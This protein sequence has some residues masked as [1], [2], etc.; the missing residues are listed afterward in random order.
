MTFALAATAMLSYLL[1]VVRQVD[2]FTIAGVS[3]F[4][5]SVSLVSGIVSGPRGWEDKE[6]EDVVYASFV[7]LFLLI[8]FSSFVFDKLTCGKNGICLS[9]SDEQGRLIS[10]FLVSVS[11]LLLGSLFFRYGSSLIFGQSKRA[12]MD[13]VG[14]HYVATNWVCLLA[15]TWCFYAS[16]K[17]GK[18]YAVA[19]L[20]IWLLIGHRAPLVLAGIAL[21]LLYAR[22]FP[23]VSLL[24]RRP[25]TF[26]GLLVISLMAVSLAKPVYGH[27]KSGGWDQVVELF[28]E[29]DL[30]DLLFRGMEF[31]GTQYIFNEIVLSN[32]VTDGGHIVRAPL[33]L[34][35]V[36]R[37]NFTTPSSEFNDL[38]QPALFPGHPAGMAYNSL[39]EFYAVAGFFG[40]FVYLLLFSLCLFLIALSMARLRSAWVV[41]VAIIGA[42][43]AFYSYR[44]S[45]AVTLGFIRYL[46]W[47]FLVAWLITKLLSA[48]GGP[49][50]SRPE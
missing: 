4:L 8:L 35:P 13:S 20:L 15:A 46:V 41:V 32:F 31:T 17:F 49:A 23:P 28:S 1:F 25:I 10:F 42:L 18:V 33:S 14:G 5:F 24:G 21:V 43:V 50:R 34:V 16:G 29:N 2:V 7:T 22:H 26:T 47:P 44:N 9:F 19:L 39:A 30:Q 36:P 11:A 45:I 48:V 3:A 37:S 6:V 12:I 27:F 40:V 38:F